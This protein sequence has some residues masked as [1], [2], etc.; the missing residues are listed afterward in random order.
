[1]DVNCGGGGGGGG[2]HVNVIL[3]GHA[4]LDKARHRESDEELHI[5][6]S[7]ETLCSMIFG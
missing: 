4:G 5:L 2:G 1:M 3:G 7:K 6:S